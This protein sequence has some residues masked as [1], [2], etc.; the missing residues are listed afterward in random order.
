MIEAEL[1]FAPSCENNKT[2]ILEVLCKH[3]Q[4][5]K[6]ILEIGGGTAQHASFFAAKL[7]HLHWQTSELPENLD[8]LNI[9]INHTARKNLPQGIAVDVNSDTWPT[10]LSSSLSQAIDTVFTANTLHI[11]S[12]ASV[13]KFFAGVEQIIPVSG[14]LIVYGPFKYNGEF[15]TASNAQFDLW[16]K[17]RNPE[18][19]IRNFEEINELAS[20]AG[21]TLI[22]DVS[23]PANNQMLIWQC[24]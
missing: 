9:R 8:T 20:A 10:D 19:G 6:S 15:T 18:S 2:P 5:S 11:M 1:P 4:A 22:E 13:Q 3:L 7:N 21:L 14:Q 23:M 16:L 24:Q 12:F 17:D